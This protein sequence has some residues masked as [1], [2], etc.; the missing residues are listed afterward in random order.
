MGKKRSIALH[1]ND[2]PLL[3]RRH[4]MKINR[5]GRNR[6]NAA[7]VPVS[8]RGP[9]PAGRHGELLQFIKR[10]RTPK[11]AHA[12]TDNFRRKTHKWTISKCE[13][14]QHC[15][16]PGEVQT[17]PRHHCP[18][19]RKA[20]NKQPR[21]TRHQ[22]EPA[23]RGTLRCSWWVCE[24]LQPFWKMVHQFLKSCTPPRPTDPT[25]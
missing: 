17:T 14:A 6:E 23:A 5:P 22:Q 2:Q 24:A 12:E 3:T 18:L 7:S 4:C 10:R 15:Q 8:D 11:W 20:R 13:D 16:S 25:P 9:G 1:Q 19:T 21:A